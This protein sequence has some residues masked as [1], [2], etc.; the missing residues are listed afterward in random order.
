[1]KIIESTYE[2][3][4]FKDNISGGVSYWYPVWVDDS[5]H[6]QVS[7]LSF[8]FVRGQEDY[9]LPH[10]HTDCQSLDLK[11]IE[12]CFDVRGDK[13]VFQGKK[14]LQTLKIGNI[15]DVDTRHFLNTSKTIDYRTPFEGLYQKW[16]VKG[17]YDNLNQSIPILKLGEI[18]QSILPQYTKL[19]S[20]GDGFKWY[21][22]V[23]IPLLSEI[24]RLG[25]RVEPTKFI[26]RWPNSKKHLHHNKVYTEYN[27]YTITGRPSNRHG[28][29]NFSALN[30]N[31]GTREVFIPREGKMF[32]QMDYDAYHPRIIGKIVD[33][34]LPKTSVH[35]WLS[36]Q[37]GCGYDEG[38]GITFQLLYGG[39]PEEFLEIPFFKKVDEFIQMFWKNTQSGGFIQTNKRRIPIEW[40]DQ[41]NAQKVFNY[42]L[43]SMET[44]LNI[45]ILKKLKDEEL[46]LPILYVYDSFLFEFGGDEIETVK[47]VKETIES[48]G[49]PIKASWG[50]D[51]SK[52]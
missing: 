44:D 4:L 38:K 47:K 50:M 32:L 33:Y 1:M 22:D 51:Y 36:D 15:L 35:Q 13:W 49:F 52:V 14:L 17:Y 11:D 25:L 20:S 6:P 42:L 39:I 3:E 7:P 26:D 10:Q 16:K 5:L 18:I 46:P 41:P 30:K 40:V 23:Y 48:L 29:V 43:Q 45:E 9:I 34:Q 27:P 28:G 19:D 37:Y 12:S 21:N 2:L 31:D 24:E 8:I